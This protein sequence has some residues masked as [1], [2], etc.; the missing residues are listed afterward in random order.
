M[1]CTVAANEASLN[2]FG[3]G[4]YSDPDIS[5]GPIVRNS[6][7]ADNFGPSAGKGLDIYGNVRSQDYNLIES[8][9]GFDLAGPGDHN[10]TGQDPLL[11]P[12]S[13]NGGD[14]QTHAL[15]SGSPAIDRGSC[16][17]IPGDPV[18]HD[19]RGVDRPQGADCDIGAYEFAQ[20]TLSLAKTVDNSFPQ[21]GRR[22]KYTITVENSGAADAT[23]G[24]ISDTL[25]V[26]LTLAGSVVLDP[27]DA[28][29]VDPLLVL[30]TDLT[31]PAGK[32][33]RA[34]FP[35]TISSDLPVGTIITNTALVTSSEV[36][37]PA[38]GTRRIV[39]MSG[40]PETVYLPLAVVASP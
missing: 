28:G 29:T 18:T 10:I 30:V 7:F 11:D 8:P 6:L 14:T 20:P 40:S 21:P 13:D 15:Q 36:G 2:P 17:D 31:F 25:P 19:Q 5:E 27:P 23:G 22:I 3:G 39:V 37:E 35:V 38:W 24:T 26:G 12:L 16:T 1:N 9:D 33:I 32:E 4:L 34:S